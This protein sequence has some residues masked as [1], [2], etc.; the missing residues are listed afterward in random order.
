L[1]KSFA[2]ELFVP[3]IV[4]DQRNGTLLAGKIVV[5]KLIVFGV[6]Q[7]NLGID[8]MKLADLFLKRDEGIPFLGIAGNGDATDGKFDAQLR[9]DRGCDDGVIAEDLFG[10]VR[11]G[12]IAADADAGVSIVREFGT[13]EM[14]RILCFSKKGRKQDF[15]NI[16]LSKSENQAEFGQLLLEAKELEV[17]AVE[18]GK[19]FG[20]VFEGEGK[21]RD[22]GAFDVLGKVGIGAFGSDEA[23][24]A[25][26]DLRGILD[27]VEDAVTHFLHDTVDGDRGAGVVEVATAAVTSGGGKQ[28]AVGGLDAI[29]QETEL[30]DQGNEGVED[31]QATALSEPASEVGKGGATGD[32]IVAESGKGPI[33]LTQ[34]GIAQDGAEVFDIGDLVEIAAEVENEQRDGIVARGAE[35]G[36]GVGGDGADE[37]E[38]DEG[39]DELREAAANGSVVVDMDKLGTELIPGEPAGFFLGKR[40]EV[41]P[42]DS[43]IDFLEVCDYIVNRELVEIHHP[44]SSWVSREAVPPSKTLSGNPFLFS[45]QIRTQPH[46]PIPTK[47]RSARLAAQ[48]Y[49]N[50]S[51]SSR[52]IKTGDVAVR[53]CSRA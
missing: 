44:G 31:F 16:G 43:G 48:S 2:G 32:G 36:I 8:G 42:V 39:G 49:A 4:I 11:V 1:E 35:D 3:G 6:E 40:F 47:T 10:L 38:I 14:D 51:S 17:V 5:M 7:M 25:G 34:P 20:S 18:G 50:G 26:D 12:G 46:Q 19:F 9:F 41:G 13:T 28:G 24:F 53:S 45:S 15:M 29:A 37:R 30:L 23:F 27:S 33:R 52:S 21:D 22:F